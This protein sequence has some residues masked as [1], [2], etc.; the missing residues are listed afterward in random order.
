[1]PCAAGAGARPRGSFAIARPVFCTSRLMAARARRGWRRRMAS[2][3]AWWRCSDERARPGTRTAALNATS[4]ALFTIGAHL[5]EDL[6]VAGLHDRPVEADVGLVVGLVVGRRSG[7]GRRACRAARPA[8]RATCSGPARR[9]ASSAA[10]GSMISRTSVSLPRKAAAGDPPAAT[11]ARRDRGG[12]RTPAGRTR[13]PVL[14]RETTSPLAA[15]TL[16]ASRTTPRLARDAGRRRQLL[17]RADLAA[18]DPPADGVDDPPVQARVRIAR[19]SAGRRPGARDTVRDSGSA[20]P[21]TQ[22]LAVDGRRR[23][24]RR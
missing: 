24:I 6:V 22:G 18:H 7:R 9:A 19:G 1:M 12:S 17:A 2:R 14:G 10:A 21:G 23:E 20:R 13:V 16:I 4:S 8:A 11:P 5:L 15:R 3:I